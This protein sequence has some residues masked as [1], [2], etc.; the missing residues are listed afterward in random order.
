MP[1]APGSL[2]GEKLQSCAGGAE[3]LCA[4]PG[5]TSLPRA[6]LAFQRKAAGAAPRH[7]VSL[8]IHSL[9]YAASPICSH[10]TKPLLSE[11]EAM[12]GS[13]SMGRLSQRDC[14]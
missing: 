2:L 13:I 3:L 11:G 8:N 12:S 1:V 14:L 6:L 9:C 4:G 5:Q 10:P 7:G